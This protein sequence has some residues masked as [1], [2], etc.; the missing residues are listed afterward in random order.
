MRKKRS[1]NDT[2]TALVSR[3]KRQAEGLRY[4]EYRSM[5]AD[6]RL[7]D[8]YDD[9]YDGYRSDRYDSRYRSYDDRPYDTY[10]RY[11]DRYRYNDGRQRTYPCGRFVNK[12]FS[13]QSKV[14][15]YLNESERFVTGRQSLS[16]IS[17]DAAGS[18]VVT[19]WSGGGSMTATTP[20]TRIGTSWTTAGAGAGWRTPGWSSGTSG[21]RTRGCTGDQSLM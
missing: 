19:G 2:E 1:V 5:M 3:L 8:R 20:G 4:S 16:V 7:Y 21:P 12:W 11:R 9:R 18:L 6:R 17:T 13:F 14:S 15:H 10:D